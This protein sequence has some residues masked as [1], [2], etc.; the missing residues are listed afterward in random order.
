MN[1]LLPLLAVTLLIPSLAAQTSTHPLDP[2]ATFLR[3]NNDLPQPPL[4]LD[5]Q[6]LGAAPRS[7]LQLETTGAFRYIA[8]GQDTHRSL[9]GVFSSSTQLLATSVQQRVPGAIAAGGAFSGGATYY[10]SLP[11]D[12]PQDFFISRNTWASGVFVEVPPAATHLFLGVFDSWYQDNVDPNG[13]Y[14]VIVTLVPPLPL[15]GTGEHLELRTGVNAPATA[16]PADKPAPGGS[17]LTGE[18]HHPVGFADGALYVLAVDLMATGGPAPMLLPRVWLGP[19]TI[20]V[21]LGV[22]PATAGWV[23]AWSIQAPPGLAGTSLIVQGG[24]LLPLARNGFY[25]TAIAHR[26]VFQ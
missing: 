11:M 9:V 26:F 25:E 3:T 16:L 24:A 2:R 10:G 8:G 21:Q 22:V 6:A 23:A 20:V 4:V 19:T 7:W 15:P 18:L 13:D 1:H 5:L 14:A 12:I 17:T